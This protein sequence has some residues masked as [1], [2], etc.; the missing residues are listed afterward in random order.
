MV[1]MHFTVHLSITHVRVASLHFTL[2]VTLALRL[3]AVEW[4]AAQ[5]FRAVTREQNTISM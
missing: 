5:D 1:L 2:T 4:S 3:E